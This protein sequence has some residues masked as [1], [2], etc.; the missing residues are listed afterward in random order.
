MKPEIADNL[1]VRHESHI[2]FLD[3]LR[4]LAILLVFL[5]HCFQLTF[6]G[7]QAGSGKFTD[8]IHQP[9]SRWPLFPLS[10]GWVGVA[11]FFV[12]SGFCIHLSHSRSKEKSLKTF[13]VRRFFRIYPPYLIALLF[14]TFLFPATRLSFYSSQDITNFWTHLFLVQ[15][16]DPASVYGIN[17]AFWSI[18]V[19]V[20]LYLIYPLLLWLVRG[21]GWNKS[22]SLILAIELVSTL[23]PFIRFHLGIA[24]PSYL[25]ALARGPLTYWFSWSIGARIADD[26]LA[27]RSI[28]MSGFPLWLCLLS[29]LACSLIAGL[30]KFAFLFGAISAATFIAGLLSSP[31][32][33]TRLTSFPFS[34]HLRKAG[35]IS[36]SFYLLHEPFL[37][38]VSSLIRP[39][40]VPSHGFVFL[41]R[42]MEWPFLLLIAWGFYRFI[43]LPSISFG[44]WQTQ[45]LRSN[46]PIAVIDP[47]DRLA[48]KESSPRAPKVN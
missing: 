12:I 1:S 23:L 44:K 4:G 47:E 20:Q 34:E 43:E 19:E 21:L 48:R 7:D 14:F 22:L 24:S 25:D 35:L 27:N 30:G 39:L 32:A 36:Y 38:G 11:L 33:A 40:F 18:A 42:L 29:F 16:F 37:A 5:F 2:L 41:V 45:R 46:H 28:F 13:F 6:S 26:W 31:M 9:L 17:G 8:W 15:N 3:H 10:L